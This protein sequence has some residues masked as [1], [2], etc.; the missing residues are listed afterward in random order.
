MNLP[1]FTDGSERITARAY[2]A[3]AGY[4]VCLFG[5]A[6]VA[7]IIPCGLIAGVGV[8]TGF[9]PLK[10]LAIIAVVIMV[11]CIMLFVQNLFRA[12]IYRAHDFGYSGWYLLWVY[13]AAN[14]IDGMIG[15][16]LFSGLFMVAPYV[17]ESNRFK[18]PYGAKTMYR[19]YSYPR[20]VQIGGQV[21]LALAVMA[22]VFG[23]LGAAVMDIIPFEAPDITQIIMDN[24]HVEGID[25]IKA[26][27]R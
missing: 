22:A 26:L 18:T 8:A 13:I 7:V 12:L 16:A 9:L 27:M 14:I 1:L 3:Y 15:I 21:S 19:W 2:K 10:V 23:L 4:L 5:I 24:V 11:V 17:L 25:K 20:F 6:L